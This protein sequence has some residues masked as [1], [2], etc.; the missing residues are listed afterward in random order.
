VNGR[1]QGLYLSPTVD[2]VTSPDAGGSAGEAEPGRPNDAGP[3]DPRAM[4]PSDPWL[5]AAPTS[6]FDG[7]AIGAAPSP[8]ETWPIDHVVA[9]GTTGRIWRRPARWT[10]A[11]LAAVAVAGCLGFAVFHQF[12]G[13]PG[14]GRGEQPNAGAG[15]GNGTGAKQGSQSAAATAPAT[16]TPT[17]GGRSPVGGGSIGAGAEPAGSSAQSLGVLVTYEVTV[18]GSHNVGSVQYTDRDGDII[19]RGGVPLPW[20]LSFRVTGQRHPLVLITQRKGGGDTGPVT[21]S[22][23]AGGKVLSTATQTGRFAAPECSASA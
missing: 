4:P 16:G 9:D 7:D 1:Q 14:T 18:S 3:V 17:A 6:A 10:L 20:R 22:I 19:R 8:A 15:P 21:C 5:A 23:T 11:L 13:D 12:G 2:V